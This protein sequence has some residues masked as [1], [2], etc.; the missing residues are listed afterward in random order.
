ML[1]RVA[2]RVNPMAYMNTTM[3]YI[4]K[5]T[6]KSWLWCWHIEQG[7]N[8]ECRGISCNIA[9]NLKSARMEIKCI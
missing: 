2:F 4:W 8:I 6:L 3:L 9:H 7:D 1:F 5:Y